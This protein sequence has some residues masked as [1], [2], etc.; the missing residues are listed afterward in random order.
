RPAPVCR[1]LGEEKSGLS[2]SNP[3][4]AMRRAAAVNACRALATPAPII[5]HAAFAMKS[6]ALRV[7][8]LLRCT[9]K[10]RATQSFI[11]PPTGTAFMQPADRRIPVA[12]L[13]RA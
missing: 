11:P 6:A 13:A 3:A 1:G 2:S 8:N 5:G 10:P 9:G 7:E 12:R 4:I